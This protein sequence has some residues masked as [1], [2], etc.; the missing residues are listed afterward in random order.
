[1]NSMLRSNRGFT[2]VEV[3]I[4]VAIV[5]IL[6]SIAY[7]SYTDYVARSNR[8]EA[9]AELLRYANMQEQYFVDSRS[10]ANTMKLLGSSTDDVDTESKNYKITVR[11][12]NN[13]YR[14]T[15]T[16]QSSQATNDASCKVMTITE[17]GV[18]S[19]TSCW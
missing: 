5:G 7:P 11:T 19:P 10:Y 15:A 1:M 16:A 4:A 8:A 9:T 14:L 6:A 18:K 17:A 2:L 3:L 12:T 13:G